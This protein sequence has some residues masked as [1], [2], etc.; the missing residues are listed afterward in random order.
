MVANRQ[1]RQWVEAAIAHSGITPTEIA[2]R[3]GL[4]L[5]TITKYLAAPQSAAMRP[6]TLRR[7]ASV[8]GYELPRE[9]DPAPPP[10]V[11]ET[12]LIFALAELL[13]K[14]RALTD[15]DR[16]HIAREIQALVRRRLRAPGAR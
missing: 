7:I 9:I 2:R 10:P 4:N 5:S 15:A 6:A 1:I 8:T 16:L 3:A 13:P 11:D 12:E 14:G